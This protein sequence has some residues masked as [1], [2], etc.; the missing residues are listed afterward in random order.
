M[1]PRKFPCKPIIYDHTNTTDPYWQN[2]VI[3]ANFYDLTS[4]K[5]GR[6]GAIAEKVG[7]I[8][9]HNFKVADNKLAGMEFSLV[10]NSMGDNATRING[11]LIVGRTNNSELALEISEPYGIIGPRTENFRV[12][13]VK[14]F[15][16]D[17]NEAAALSSC[18]HCFHPAATDSGARTIRFSN[19]TIDSSVKRIANYQYPW[20]AIFLD[21]D[22]TLTGK[23][24]GSWATPYYKHHNQTGCERNASYYG[25]V[26]CDNTVQVRRIAFH[27]TKPAAIF[28]GM[29][30][31]I[32]RYDDD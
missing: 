17:W 12:D 6:N 9:W 22:G 25:G 1:V 18:S 13:G 3:T 5:N 7:D 11:G 29:G 23:G 2:P 8:R 19:L 30:F 21:E 31:K 4:W 14:F 24:P 15:N 32:L 16:F 28:R 10:D 26:F 20:R 27:G